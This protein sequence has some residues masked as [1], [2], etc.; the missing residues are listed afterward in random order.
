MKVIT[1][2]MNDDKLNDINNI[3][4][5]ESDILFIN[6]ISEEDY[7]TI[8]KNFTGKN[9][10]YY[11]LNEK[12][13]SLIISR[14]MISIVSNDYN[15]LQN[16]CEVYIPGSDVTLLFLDNKGLNLEYKSCIKNNKLI[17]IY[18]ENGIKEYIYDDIKTYIA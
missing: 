11:K 14:L 6:N 12:T 15:K 3:L 1:I 17:I 18:Q 2:N 13:S 8:K 7:N 9:Y 16:G 4:E 10:C 5:F